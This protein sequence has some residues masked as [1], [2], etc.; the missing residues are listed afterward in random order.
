MAVGQFL[1]PRGKYVYITDSG[2]SY[3]ITTDV[4]IGALTPLALDAFVSQDVI[5]KL[6]RG[7]KPRVVHWRSTV[8]GDKSK[9]KLICNA[10]G[11]AYN[12]MVG[13]ALPVDGVN[14]VITGRTG[15]RVTF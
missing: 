5:G 3:V 2:E 10:A 9:K 7:M 15:E 12:S 14:G 13:S 11:S 8:E 4:T 1:G 6:P